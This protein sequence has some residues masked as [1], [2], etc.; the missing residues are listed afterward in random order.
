MRQKLKESPQI[1]KLACDLGLSPDGDPVSVILG[2]C[3]KK[4]RKIAKEFKCA[5]LSDLLNAAATV[6][7]TRFVEVRCESDLDSLQEKYVRKGEKRF[8]TLRQD[9]AGDVLAITYRLTN[10]RPWELPYVSVI[11]CRGDR[12]SRAYYSRWHELGHLLTLTDQTR[13]SFTRTHAET[14]Q[15]RD[16]EETLMEI[17]AGT[18]GFWGELA[19][20]KDGGRITFQTIDQLRAQHCAEASAQASLIGFVSAWPSACVLVHAELG[21][22]ECDKRLSSQN[23]LGFAT[24]PVPELRAVK[25]S[26]NA[27]AKSA[28]IMIYENMRIP[29]CSIIYK[30]FYGEAFEGT[31]EENLGDWT[32]SRGGRLANRRVLVEAKRT[33]GAVEALITPN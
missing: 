15:S 4:I 11:D 31:A 22:K 21:L 7:G 32:T 24:E 1:W 28:G 19:A 14:S 26:P 25:V 13:L 6:L 3:R 33:W 20:P 12:A 16:P 18:F 23:H 30:V 9:L 8:A 10:N 27:A 5:T 17:I 29:E 2:F